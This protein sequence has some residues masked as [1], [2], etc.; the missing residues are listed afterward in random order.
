MVYQALWQCWEFLCRQLIKLNLE[1]FLQSSTWS[2]SH[3]ELSNQ[4]VSNKTNQFLEYAMHVVEFH[5]EHWEVPLCALEV[6]WHF[7][8]LFTVWQI[9]S[10][11]PGQKSDSLECNKH[12]SIPWWPLCMRSNIS[13]CSV[14]SM[15][16][17]CDFNKIPSSMEISS[18]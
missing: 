7:E 2:S 6:D 18:L 11:I 16:I 13:I 1:A 5:L 15:S 10:V 9:S 4:N 17:L 3:L 14:C 8:H 12:F